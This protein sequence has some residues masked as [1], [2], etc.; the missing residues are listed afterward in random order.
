[1]RFEP[2]ARLEPLTASTAVPEV[3][4]A[5]L[6]SEVEPAVNVTVPVGVVL[7]DAGFT[8]AVNWVEPVDA[9]LVGLPETVVVVAAGG[10]VTTTVSD[11][12]EPTNPLAPE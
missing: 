3:N 2:V 8:V 9:I 10:A 1:M 5:A 11:A 6:P 12:V 7:P 4:R